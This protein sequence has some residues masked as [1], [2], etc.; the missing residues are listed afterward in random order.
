MIITLVAGARPNFM[1]VAPII[2]SIDKA[3]NDGNNISYRLIHTGQHYDKALSDTFFEELAIPKPDANLEVGSG[4]QAGQTAQIMIRFEEELVRHPTDVVLV[5]GDVNSTMACSIVAK[6]L[7][8]QLVHVEAGIRSFDMGMPEEINRMVTDVLSD[9]FFTTSEIANNNLLA[10]GMTKDRIHFVG[11]TMI[12]TLLS[13]INHFKKP[14][15]WDTHNLKEKEF[16]ILTLHRPSNVD[17]VNTLREIILEINNAS[18]GRPVIFPVHP[19]TNS[20]LQLI[21][22][23]LGSVVPVTPMGY[24]EFMYLV[25]S[26]CCAITDSGGLQEETTVLG[27]PCITLRKNSERPETYLIGT[28]ELLPYIAGLKPLMN[29]IY[30]GQWKKGS[31]PELWDGKTAARIVDKLIKIYS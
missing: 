29:R 9:H 31:I 24:L 1:K 22:N 13:Q 16:I 25:R 3:R 28:N 30:S 4:S 7:G 10:S 2:K 11:N 12:D 15:F 20:N 26:T 18:Q 17:N 14:G 23:D 19:R 27:V 21:K 6:K 5:V 8:T